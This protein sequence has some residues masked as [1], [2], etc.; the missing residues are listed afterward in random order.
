[1][2]KLYDMIYKRKSIRKFDRSL[3]VTKDELEQ[4]EHYIQQ[5]EPLSDEI[6]IRFKIVDSAETT[7]KRG[8]YCLLMY[9]E[10]KPYDLL[11]AG[12]M[13]ERIDLYLASLDIGACWYGFGKPK[14]I[15]PEG[16]DF[17]I[18]IAFGKCR[19]QDFRKDIAKCRRRKPDEIWEGSFYRDIAA[20]VRYAPSSCNMQPWRVVSS[21]Q[22]ISVYR[23]EH[24]A[25][26]MPKSKRPFYNTIDMGIFLCFL[27]ICLLH[28][29][30]VFSRE[31]FD[32]YEENGLIKIA[33]YELKA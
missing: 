9:S 28:G 1:M 17:I 20:E 6:K 29:N 18:M 12:Y 21:N 25:S 15:D 4:L 13:L 33:Q 26:I 5:I 31:L 32:R 27:E 19:S 30:Y 16:L 7:C 23:T 22:S 8:E 24:V 14:E 10:K 2:D 3:T 11:N